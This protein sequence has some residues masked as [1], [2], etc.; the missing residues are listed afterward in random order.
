MYRWIVCRESD[1]KLRSRFWMY[2]FFTLSVP[3]GFGIYHL[4]THSYGDASFYC[5]IHNKMYQFYHFFLLHYLCVAGAI[6]LIFMIRVHV[7]RCAQRNENA[8]ADQSSAIIRR[9][10][11]LYTMV[12]IVDRI[13]SFLYRILETFGIQNF[14]LAILM[15]AFLNLH[16]FA[17]CVIYGGV[18]IKNNKKKKLPLSSPSSPLPPLHDTNRQRVTKPT[19]VPAI[20]TLAAVE[21]NLLDQYDDIDLENGSFLTDTALIQNGGNDTTG[22]IQKTFIDHLTET[23]SRTVRRKNVSIFVSTFNMGEAKVTLDSLTCW[24]PLGHDVYVIGVQECM[25]LTDFRTKL[26]KHLNGKNSRHDGGNGG[27][28]KEKFTFFC[29]EIGNRNTALGYHVSPC[30]YQYNK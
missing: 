20:S 2:L 5:W 12:F 23:T 21:K 17:N 13:P 28:E 25:D 24:V 29:R 6:I 4:T 18:L 26:R 8:E 1:A 9:R 14:L 30:S 10:L 15:Q 3:L 22:T 19:V 11:L 7:K 27:V 16:G